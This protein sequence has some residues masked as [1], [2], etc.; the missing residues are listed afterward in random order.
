MQSPLPAVEPAIKGAVVVALLL[1][2]V[3]LRRVG[4]GE[5][6]FDRRTRLL[7]GIPWGTLVSMAVVV[8]VYLFVQ[9]GLDHWYRPVTVAFS[10]W[11]YF[12][13]VGWLTAAFSH[14]GP[15]HLLGNLFGTVVF[16]P[17]AEYFF[18]HYPASRGSRSFADWRTNPYVRAFL[19]FPLGV[20]GVGLLSSVFAW[21]PVI[22]FSGVVFAFAGFALVRYPIAV[23]VATIVQ[24]IVGR[25]Y[26][27]LRDPIFSVTAS[28]TF[29]T[30]WW[31]QI[32]IQGHALGFFLGVL[33]GV[34]LLYRRNVRPDAKR[35][36]LGALGF[37]I[38]LNLWAVYW[39]RGNDTFVLYQG[40]GLV[41]VLAIALVVALVPGVRDGPLVSTVSRRQTAGIGVAFAL[42][43]APELALLIRVVAGLNG[44][45]VTLRQTVALTLVAAVALAVVA[46]ELS[47]PVLRDLSGRQLAVVGLLLPL[48]VMA[49]VAIPTNLRALDDASV[50]NGESAVHV[51]GYSV[52][53]AEDVPNQLVS[54]VDVSAFGETTTVNTSG[55]IVVNP[56]REI[57]V[58][59]ISKGKL[60]FRGHGGVRVGGV[61]WRETVRVQRA[62]WS[63]AGGGTA[64]QIW[65][66]PS[67][68]DWRHVFSSPPATAGPVLAG[69]NVSVVPRN[70]TFSL[71]VSRNGSALATFRIPAEGERVRAAGMAFVREKNRVVASY[72]GT[73]IV[74]ATKETYQD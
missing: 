61:G 26:D 14:A 58:R 34:V 13:S 54:V 68:E 6:G 33:L 31:A 11:S 1:S 7:L 51:R 35:L 19:L 64:Y 52:T 28:P 32:A 4:R 3:V 56:E 15:G 73:R 42:L 8:G 41:L 5:A 65:L 30:P 18:G 20:L 60:A 69:K 70:G 17:I 21:G 2:A 40:P 50:P 67:D 16:A 37:A 45:T 9:S 66:K 38:S 74:V 71:R 25:F 29:S 36:W 22:G 63:A 62:G 46:G 12:Y 72:D 44:T 57:W 59:S 39:F 23:L 49:G 27:A 43:A 55:V 53:Y 10:S 47:K 24:G 48:V